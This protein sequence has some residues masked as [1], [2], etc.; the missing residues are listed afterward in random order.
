MNEKKRKGRLPGLDTAIAR[1]VKGLNERDR[2]KVEQEVDED[3]ALVRCTV[4]AT[5]LSQY[6]AAHEFVEVDQ[7]SFEVNEIV[8]GERVSYTVNLVVQPQG[9]VWV[10]SVS[11]SSLERDT[12]PYIWSAR[13]VEQFKKF[14]TFVAAATFAKT[15]RL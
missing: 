5:L 10:K 15:G 1:H 12:F 3:P 4:V 13:Y 2:A 6:L 11:V 9:A 14:A 7:G 8:D